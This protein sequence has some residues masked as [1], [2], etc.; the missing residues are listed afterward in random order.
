MLTL[1]P[2]MMLGPVLVTAVPARTP[3]LAAV[4][5]PT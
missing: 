1:G 3:N 2:L 4:P 5:R